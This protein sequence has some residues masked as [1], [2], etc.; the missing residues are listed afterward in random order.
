MLC[1]PFSQTVMIQK[2]NIFIFYVKLLNA[3]FEHCYIILELNNKKKE[4]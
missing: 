4:N 1:G 3:Y 2:L